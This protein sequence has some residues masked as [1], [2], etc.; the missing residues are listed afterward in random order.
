MVVLLPLFWMIL[1]AFKQPG[2]ALKFDFFPNTML[3]GPWK[4]VQL[5]S[6]DPFLILE[7]DPKKYPE[8]SNPKLV[9]VVGDFNNWQEDRDVLQKDRHVWFIKLHN[10]EVGQKY[11]YQFMVN[12]Q[13]KVADVQSLDKEGD[14]SSLTIHSGRNTNGTLLDDTKEKDGRIHF[15]IS[16]SQSDYLEIEWASEKILVLQEKDG[17]FQG[18][19]EA[20]EEYRRYR[21]LQ[22][23]SFAEATSA[24]YTWNNFQEVLH[25]KDFPFA[26][27]FLNSVI[28]STLTALF[29][30][31]LCLMGGYTFSKKRFFGKNLLLL[32]LLSSMMIPGMI[33]M[34]PQFILVSKLGWMNSYQG[35][36]VPHL[37]NVFGLFLFKQYIDTIPDS[38]FEAA[39]LDGASEWQIFRI[40]LIPLSMPI[41]ATLFLL[42]FVGQWSNFLWQ[43]IVNTP[44]SMYRTLP[45]GLALFKGQY[46]TN[47]E[48]M[49]AGACFSIIPIAIVFL[50]AQRFFIAGMTSGAVK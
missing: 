5:D 4:E 19:C 18:S 37:A 23:R 15:Q 8:I 35:M 41:M 21:I 34:V 1:T 49:M 7:F 26:S 30:V 14:I 17:I 20:S 50:S 6:P 48:L 28:V 40:I 36:I 47:W 31:V 2:Q 38:L 16:C 45:V 27:F 10:F 42:T 11:R 44:D 29:T 9:A 39:K 46:A 43:L 24:I 12:G 13:H 32:I 3:V 22:A 25:N 33:F